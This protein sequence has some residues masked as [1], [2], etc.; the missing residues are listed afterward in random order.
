MRRSLLLA[1]ALP[2]ASVSVLADADPL[3]SSPPLARITTVSDNYFGT[4]VAD[5]YRWLEQSNTPEVATRIKVENDYAR[6]VIA[7]IPGRA[8][9]LQRIRAL[10]DTD[11]VVTAV[12]RAGNRI[13]YLKSV[14][15]STI[16]ALFVRD[17][18]GGAER[19]LLDPAKRATAGHHFA[20]DYYSPSLD[21]NMVACGVS[22]GGSEDAVIEVID[23]ASARPLTDRI[24][25]ARF[26]QVSWRPDHRSF[27]YTRTQKRVPGALAT[28]AFENL[29]VHLHTLGE[30]PEKDPAVLG[31]GVSPRVALPKTIFPSVKVLPGTD[32]VVGVISSGTSPEKEVYVAPLASVHGGDAPWRKVA[33]T[34]DSVSDLTAHG[35]DLFFLTFRGAPRYQIV[36]TSLSH[37]D[38]AHATI[39]VPGGGEVIQ[40][41]GAAQDG[42][43]VE[44]MVAGLTTIRRLPFI[45]GK[46]GVVEPLTLPFAGSSYAVFGRTAFASALLPGLLFQLESWTQSPRWFA[47]D[48]SGGRITDTGLAPPSA[49]DFSQIESREV[50]VTAKDGVQVPLS[51]VHKR[52]LD[53][54]GKHPTWLRGYGA[55]GIS[56][57][58]TFRPTM[59][60]W[61]EQGGV[62]ATAHVRGGGEFGEEW[63]AAGKKQTKQ[64]TF[65]DFI[66]CAEYLVE[67][68]YTSPVRLG[69]EGG[70]AGGI[71]LGS[72][73]TQRPD[74][75]AAV[76]IRVGVLDMMRFE[77]TQGGP[78]NA[79]EFGSIKAQ[80]DFPALYNMSA[81]HHV[82][83]DTAYP[84]ALLT[85]GY[86]D[87]R[88]PYWQPA[89]MAV[90]LRAASN[91]G[92]PVLLRVEYDG[93]H[94]LGSTKEQR[95]TELADVM[96]FLGWQLAR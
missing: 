21:G 53:L 79:F 62:F 56:Y 14:P 3:P 91:S 66:A 34:A 93:G 36:R 5:P 23:V 17:R 54:D 94:G 92:K 86:T 55:Y 31:S 46:L 69:A 59:L 51:I 75:F 87:G 22:P 96:A 45:E 25:R 13:F 16:P 67:H 42:L 70:S 27:F 60:P 44:S 95:D 33:G 78:A 68:R 18:I 11:S 20:I 35:D 43:Y 58:P 6:A 52:G 90:R 85:A 76:A 26:G 57:T 63:H 28:A 24:D 65:D 29:R 47:T 4:T 9:L 49:V 2:A 77:T 81:Y 71:L 80:S 1:F 30:N 15:G 72:V 12:Q 38:L 73:I 37:P 83:P 64:N 61:L 8:A 89:K 39:V 41:V 19:V 7:R 48:G 84:A 50:L 10:G 88:V 74:L 40:W 82:K 32:F